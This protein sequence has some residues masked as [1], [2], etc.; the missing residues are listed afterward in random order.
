[1]ICIFSPLIQTIKEKSELCV[2]YIYIG[3]FF[4]SRKARRVEL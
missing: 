1:M 4:Y 3:D 2:E